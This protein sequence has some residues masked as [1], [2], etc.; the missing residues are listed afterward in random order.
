MMYAI[1]AA[2][3]GQKFRVE[4]PTLDEALRL[5]FAKDAEDA[6]REPAR[7]GEQVRAMNAAGCRKTDR[8]I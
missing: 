1:E 8:K 2:S 4:A 7:Q 3:D 6:A 5:W